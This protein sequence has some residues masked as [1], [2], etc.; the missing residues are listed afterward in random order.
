MCCVVLCYIT[1]LHIISYHISHHIIYI[2]SY[3]LYYINLIGPP[4]YMRS[5]VDRNVVSESLL[6]TYI[7]VSISLWELL[8]NRIWQP[9]TS[10]VQPLACH[11]TELRNWR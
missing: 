11:Y 5:V 1:L 9:N 3:I 8:H 6:V 4:S 2:I 7:T 10:L